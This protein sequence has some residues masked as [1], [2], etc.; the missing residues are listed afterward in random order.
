MWCH[1]LRL[2]QQW[3]SAI[4]HYHGTVLRLFLAERCTNAQGYETKLGQMLTDLVFFNEH[5]AVVCT[6]L[7]VKNPTASQTRRRTTL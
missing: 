2:I 1:N 5:S 4:C 7:T 3:L 6:N